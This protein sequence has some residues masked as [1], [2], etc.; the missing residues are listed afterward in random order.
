MAADASKPSASGRQP[1]ARLGGGSASLSACTGGSRTIRLPMSAS[2]SA[3]LADLA[4]AVTRAASRAGVAGVLVLM[5]ACTASEQPTGGQPSVVA[6]DTHPPA[7]APQP[8]A[9][10]SPSPIAATGTPTAAATVVAT[11][12]PTP[13]PPYSVALPGQLDQRRVSVAV[14]PDLGAQ[15]PRLVVRVTSAA[16]ARIGDLLLRWSEELHQV[17]YLAPFV[18][19][20]DR[21]ADGGM[22]LSQFVDWTRWVIGPGS[23]GEPEGTVTLG[24]GPLDPGAT[25]EI[26]LYI[27]RR[28]VADPLSFDLQVIASEPVSGDPPRRDALLLLEDGAPAELRVEL[29]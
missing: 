26:P 4:S 8:A 25:L 19:T 13:D 21:V 1:P 15:P 16:D 12:A 14:T 10:A 5:I 27:L 20:P 18:A 9:T 23:D 29:P 28:D 11:P 2:R 6:T 17:L 22:P 7:T 3:V 24:Y